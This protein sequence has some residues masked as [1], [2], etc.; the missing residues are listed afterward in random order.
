M[1]KVII[2]LGNS[3]DSTKLE[4]SLSNK[5]YQKLM[6]IAGYIEE[7][8]ECWAIEGVEDK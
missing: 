5:E 6:A 1:K 2:T 3:F 4:V 7:Y 8:D